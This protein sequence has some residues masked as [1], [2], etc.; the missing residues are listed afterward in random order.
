MPCF[1]SGKV[2][3][4]KC[5]F[6]T[7]NFNPSNLNKHMHSHHSE[8]DAPAFFKA[9]PSGRGKAACIPGCSD[10]VSQATEETD[11]SSTAVNTVFSNLSSEQV[12]DLWGRKVHKFFN[13]C[14][15]PSHIASSDEFRDLMS[16]TV[17]NAVQL[18]SNQ[19]H[20]FLRPH[21]FSQI[22]KNRLQELIF[23][24]TSLVRE[25]HLYF[26]KAT[27]KM[28]PHLSVTHDVWESK[29]GLWLGITLYLIDVN[30][31][32]MC[33]IPISFRRS[34]G[35]VYQQVLETIKRYEH[36]FTFSFYHYISHI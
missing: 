26:R 23:V 27:G 31:W 33:S 2:E 20:L 19:D 17:N 9:I 16:F 21:K 32:E 34:N 8:E 25:S 3:L 13:R 5:L 30:R 24:V 7:N 35:N 6:S 1:N 28:I 18:K 10:S 36:F 11:H 4:V 29:N 22:S 12:F 14:G 15:I